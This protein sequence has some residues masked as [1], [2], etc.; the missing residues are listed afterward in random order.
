M[1][2]TF[3]PTQLAD[4]V[5]REANDIVRKCV[6]CGFCLATCPTYLLLGDERDSPR[7]RIYVVKELLE[8]DAPATAGV[9]RPLDRC[10]TCLSCTTT[11]PSGVDYAHLIGRARV[12]V[13]RGHA[14]PLPDRLL[15]RMLGMIVPR[16]WLLRVGMLAGRALR[17]L[18]MLVPGRLKGMVSMAADRVAMPSSVDRPQVFPAE[19]ERRMRVA[20]L[21]GCA[22]RVLRPQINEATI[23]VLRRHGCEVVVAKGAGCCGAL[24]HQ[25][26]REDAA[27]V[28]ARANVRAWSALRVAGPLDAVV[29]NASGCGVSLKDYGHLLRDDAAWAQP[30]AEIASLAHDVSEILLDLGLKPAAIAT[31]QRVAYHLA[32]T[33]Q[34]GLGLRA[35]AKRLLSD[36]G[37]IVA[38]P[39]EPHVCCGSAGLYAI[40]EPDLA[41]RLRQRK[42]ANIEATEPQIIASDNIGCITHL[43]AATAV[44]VVHTA[45]LLDWATG[46]PKPAALASILR[47]L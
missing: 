42:V 39:A 33:M 26:G 8:N 19:G 21:S 28:A 35:E 3:S 9:V 10:R 5:L 13:E 25:L 14:R 27:R 40:L 44:P 6:H 7:G 12:Y 22:Q 37:F 24:D 4:P 29:F 45:E 18:R 41:G 23:R 32:C 31:G 30:A 43:A 16:P 2:T 20:L 46:G 36:A 34:H 47:G 38:E 11:C 17:P 15:R 1:R